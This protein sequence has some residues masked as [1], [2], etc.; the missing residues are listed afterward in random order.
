MKGDSRKW[1]RV[2]AYTRPGFGLFETV[3][4][5][6]MANARHVFLPPYRDDRH[7]FSMVIA[8]PTGAKLDPFENISSA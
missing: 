7:G 6:L 8:N 5:V 3:L 1:H 2:K 4:L